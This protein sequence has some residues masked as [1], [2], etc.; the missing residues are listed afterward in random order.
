MK[1]TWPMSMPGLRLWPQSN[2]M[3]DRSSSFSPVS[4]STS[5]CEVEATNRYQCQV[6]RIMMSERLPS[7]AQSSGG[8]N[9]MISSKH[10]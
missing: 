6:C 4:T 9:R 7:S 5:T 3:S 10:T 1:H 2:R 8:E